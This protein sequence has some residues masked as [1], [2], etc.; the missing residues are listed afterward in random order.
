LSK[1]ECYKF[2]VKPNALLRSYLSDR[3]QRVLINNSSSN[4]TTFS[5]WCKI[6]H[7]IHQ[8]SIL[9]PLF[10]LIYINA[11]PNITAHPLKTIQFA[12][13]TRI[14]ISNPS[15][16]KFKENINNKIDNKIT[17]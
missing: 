6:K 10:F 4:T 1:C 2:R 12:D 7:G 3:Y 8:G 16:S 14:K 13:D 9:G 17:S 15:P 5:D 11:L